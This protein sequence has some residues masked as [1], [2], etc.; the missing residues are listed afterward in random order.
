MTIYTKLRRLSSEKSSEEESEG[1]SEVTAVYF[2]SFIS[3]HSLN[4]QGH[5]VQRCETIKLEKWVTC[6]CKSVLSVLLLCLCKE[7]N[8][9]SA[10]VSKAADIARRKLEQKF[11][12]EQKAKRSPVRGKS[13][14]ILGKVREELPVTASKV[15][16]LKSPREE[17]P[18][19]LVCNK[20]LFICALI[21]ILSAQRAP[22]MT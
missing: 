12:S 6:A 16:A 5:C 20:P 14:H 8:L 15:N 21:R 2:Y 1:N 3:S 19:A 7:L 10:F 9:T 13:E 11:K 18:T 17:K 4:Y 22:N